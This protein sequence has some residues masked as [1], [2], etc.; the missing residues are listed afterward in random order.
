MAKSC[1]VLVLS[2]LVVSCQHE[3]GPYLALIPENGAN[4][5]D[6]GIPVRLVAGG[7]DAVEVDISS[8]VFST[9]K[10]AVTTLCQ[11]TTGNVASTNN[12]VDTIVIVKPSDVQSLV[13]AQLLRGASDCQSGTEVLSYDVV[14]SKMPPNAAPD[15]EIPPD[16]AVDAAML[17]ASGVDAQ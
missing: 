7:G 10:G 5:T 2:L 12:G 15:A 14:V 6:L 11:P 1:F 13:V 17:D 9:P 8:G 3:D 16:G 4:G